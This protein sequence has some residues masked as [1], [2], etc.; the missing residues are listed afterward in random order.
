MTKRILFIA[1]VLL[2]SSLLFAACLGSAKPESQAGDVGQPGEQPSAPDGGTG[3]EAPLEAPSQVGEGPIPTEPVEE[4]PAGAPPAEAPPAD[5]PTQLPGVGPTEGEALGD[6][7][8]EG[9]QGKAQPVEEDEPEPSPAGDKP[10]PT[11]E[12]PTPQIQFDESEA[13]FADSGTPSAAADAGAAGDNPAVVRSRTVLVNFGVL[14]AAEPAAEGGGQPTLVLNLFDDV[15]V[16]AVIERVEQTGTGR[17]AWVGSVQGVDYSDVILIISAKEK[18]LTGSVAMPGEYYQI[19]PTDDSLHVIQE[20][21]P[22]AL[23]D[24]APPQAPPTPKSGSQAGAASASDAPP[25]QAAGDPVAPV[26]FDILVVYTDDA[27]AVQG[28]Q[29]AIEMLI[30]ARI[31]ET[32]T[33]YANS[34]IVHTMRL[35]HAEEISYAESTNWGQMLNHLTF[36]DGVIDQVHALRDAYA[37]DLVMMVVAEPTIACGLA[38]VMD[39]D[40]APHPPDP[41]LWDFSPYAFSIVSENCMVPGQYTFSHEPGHN[42]GAQHDRDNASFQGAY[43]YSYGLQVDGAFRTIMAYSAGCLPPCPRIPHFSNPD[44]SYGGEW[45]GIPIGDLDE[46]HNAET[47]NQTGAGAVAD[48]RE[49]PDNDDFNNA[50]VIGGLPYS[51]GQSTLTATDDTD[52]PAPSC[53]PTTGMTVWYDYTPTVGGAVAFS[54]EGSDFDTTLSVWTGTRTDLTEVACSN[55][56]DGGDTSRVGFFAQ[57]E[58]TYHIMVGGDGGA[59]G[60]PEF[61]AIPFCDTVTEIPG[62]ECEALAALYS[63]TNGASWTTNTN[64]MDDTAPC[65]SPWY[66]VTCSGGHVTELDLAANDLDGPLPAELGDLSELQILDLSENG[67]DGTIP[68]DLG[69]LSNLVDL[70]LRNNQLSGAI[71]SQLGSMPMLERLW[72][73][74][75]NLTGSIPP[76]LGSLPSLWNLDLKGNEL[77]GGIPVGLTQAPS[78][79]YL[80]LSDN[81]LSGSIPAEIGDLTDLDG[82]D[83]SYNQFSGPIPATIGNLDQVDELNLSHNQLTGNLPAT[84]G[85][86]TELYSLIIDNNALAGDIPAA[87]AGLTNLGQTHPWALPCDFG[88]NGLYTS[89]PAVETLFTFADPDWADTQTITP[90]DL[91]VVSVSSGSVELSWTP[92][93]YTGDGGYYE[94]GISPSAG[95]P[96]TVVASTADK[97]A[98]GGTAIKLSPETTYYI[99]VR[100]FTPAHG[101]QQ[102]DLWSDFSAPVS[103]KTEAVYNPAAVEDVGDVTFIGSAGGPYQIE[104]TITM[105][106]PVCGGRTK[107]EQWRDGSTAYVEITRK[108]PRSGVCPPSMKEVEL[109]LVL[110]GTFDASTTWTIN[111]NGYELVVDVPS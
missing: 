100:T 67:L 38:W 74:N 35:V 11:A 68:G 80:N 73:D 72:L 7:P 59:S 79:L 71:P 87:L 90:D 95:G 60:R 58:T 13:L 31:I 93:T 56:Y 91:A 20:I 46:A 2:L 92:I 55:D 21:D 14:A 43:S 34:D 45:T 75:N 97:S 57:T 33:A 28:S 99:V 10:T 17:T 61:G 30:D 102:N 5:A 12:T 78:L 89:T 110:D 81:Q 54:T 101:D 22:T 6:Q 29:A 8:E 51:R 23:P 105:L 53:A 9:D 1:A 62:A 111:I 36:V 107:I 104:V 65:T 98:S 16:R 70:F 44:V 84:M 48:F 50:V 108:K 83:L 15:V 3:G 88:Y 106:V 37:A 52:D 64:W 85:G 39:E 69:D 86:M 26:V 42:M 41:P 96:F 32:N 82:L 25:P 40:F 66:G 103:A 4:A 47:L 63:D 77:T 18:K 19:S 27:R 109:V 76:Q 49:F 94:I 24:E